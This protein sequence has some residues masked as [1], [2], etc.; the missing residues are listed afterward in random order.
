VLLIGTRGCKWLAGRYD[1]TV[2]TAHIGDNE[3]RRRIGVRHRLADGTKAASVAE[4][5]RSLVVLHAT[6]PATVFLEVWAR[7]TESSPE[8]IERQLYEE[9]TVLRMLAMRR[10]LWLVPL[11]DVPMIFAAG[12]RDVAERERPRTLKILADGMSVPYPADR[13]A[14]LEEIALAAIRQHGEVATPELRNLDPR[15]AER[16]TIARGKNYQGSMPVISRVVHHLALDGRIGRGRPRGTWISGQFRWSPIERW[17]PAGIPPMAVDEARAELVRHW[18]RA[19]GPGTRDDVRWWTGWTVGR[20]RAAL[21]A[22]GAVEVSLDGGG[23]GYALPDDLD[24]TPAVDPWVAFLP[25]LDA[26]TMG[27]AA[28][29]WYLGPYRP[30]LFDTNG[31]AG[32][33]IWVDGRIVGGWAQR[34]SGEVVP[35]LLKD[36]GTDA[37]RRIEAEAARLEAWLGPARVSG[38]FPT[39]LET[40]LRTERGT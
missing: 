11:P 2:T 28:R 6:D 30:R 29:D 17:F 14:E 26:T 15:L 13:F 10:T 9:P 5:A 27:W 31:N 4:A 32:P 19:F 40:E 23:V 12:S 25:A 24:W 3:R 35:M 7:T 33:T 8:A 18:L 39:P 16:V 22:A 37:R 34:R 21:E 1:R 36:V 20:T 38:S